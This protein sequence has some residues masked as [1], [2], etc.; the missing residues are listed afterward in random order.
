MEIR[1]DYDDLADTIFSNKAMKPRDEQHGLI[2]KLHAEIAELENEQADYS[3][4][5]VERREQF[6]RIL[7]QGV[8]MMRLIRDEKEEAERKE[9]MDDLDDDTE[10][11][12][13]GTPRPLPDGAT[14]QHPAPDAES[15]SGFQ[16]VAEHALG[17]TAPFEKRS[18]AASTATEQEE[19]ISGDAAM[20]DAGDSG[21]REI[22]DEQAEEEAEEGEEM[23]EPDESAEKMDTT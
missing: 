22:R 12:K 5:W 11:S 2:E 7:E 20:A 6:D 15:G 10:T 18:R 1:K 3:R 13:T 4:T 23:E 17:V 14:P 21:E 9:D 8:Q 19:S 16:R